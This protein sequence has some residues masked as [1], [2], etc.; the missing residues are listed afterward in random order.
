MRIVLAAVRS[1]VD[2]RLNVERLSS[3][4]ERYSGSADLIVLPEA[5]MQGFDA[6]TDDP[7]RDLSVGIE[8]DGPEILAIQSLCAQF[9]IAI[10]LPFIE[11]DGDVLYSSVIVFDGDGHQLALYRRMSPGW[12]DPEVVSGPYAEGT[13]PSRFELKNQ[14]FV[15]ALCGDVWE[16][17]EVFAECAE[18]TDILLWPLYVT[19]PPELWYDDEVVYYAKQSA[20][21]ADR[22]LV[23]NAVSG[24]E[25]SP[26]DS[27]AHGGAVSVIAGSIE[28]A[29]PMGDEGCL[30]V[31]IVR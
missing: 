16:R 1:E 6:I 17:P 29:L 18:S 19:F 11:R 5:Y 25:S 27:R 8:R 30:I 3:L 20:L 28:Q 22:A 10:C 14:G 13:A 26:S 31:D 21:I 7:I 12:R 4:C 23:V 2:V 24:S 15:L 9:S